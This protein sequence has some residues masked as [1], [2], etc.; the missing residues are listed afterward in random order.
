ML[1]TVDG[2][3]AINRGLGEM[4]RERLGP[5]RPVAV[6]PSAAHW[7]DRVPA[8]AERDLD[9]VYLGHIGEIKGVDVLVRAMA[10]LPGRRLRIHGRARREESV[11]R[12]R[13]RI[14]ELGLGDRVTLGDWI[15]PAEVP[16]LLA[17]ARVSALPYRAG[18]TETARFV[19]PLKAYELMAAGVPVV[20]SDLPSLREILRDGETGLLVPPDD[21]D[22]L[23]G[24]LRRVL[25]EPDLAQ[26]LADRAREEA[27]RHSWA[28]RARRM[29]EFMRETR[30]A[31]RGRAS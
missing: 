20:A 27:R 10:K 24:A 26:R 8:A 1:R 14:D 16:P 3:V 17:R 19:S 9:V 31:R 6:I 7:P 11:A 23:A 4:L 28:E 12:L 2:L 13:R 18:W 25:E 22:A 5:N 15:P 29:A 21:P 30:D